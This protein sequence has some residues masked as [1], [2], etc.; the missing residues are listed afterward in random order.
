MI[1]EATEKLIGGS[2]LGMD[3]A[4]EVMTQI[5]EGEATPVQLASFLTALRM[6]GETAEEIAGM[7][8]VMRDKALPVKT[9]RRGGGYVWH[10]WSQSQ[11]LQHLHRNGLRG[12]WVRA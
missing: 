10:G 3:E 5:M 4:S 11:D 7:A 8:L 12:G 2:S 9:E 1:R 6:K